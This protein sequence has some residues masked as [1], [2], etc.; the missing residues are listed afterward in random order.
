MKS[1]VHLLTKKLAPQYMEIGRSLKL[2]FYTKHDNQ[3]ID[4]VIHPFFAKKD[5]GP[6][7]T[8]RYSS[9]ILF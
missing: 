8:I 9:L 3:P 1:I 4:I 2:Y 7:R 5:G 6:I